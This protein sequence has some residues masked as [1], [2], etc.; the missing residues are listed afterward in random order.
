MLYSCSANSCSTTNT[1]NND[2]ILKL[3]QDYTQIRSANEVTGIEQWN[4]SIGSLKLAL[5]DEQGHSTPC[6]KG[7]M[8]DVGL[9]LEIDALS[10]QMHAFSKDNLVEWSHKV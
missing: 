9:N 5:L 7:G 6:L 2:T 8:G 4:F 3:T 1:Q 10:G